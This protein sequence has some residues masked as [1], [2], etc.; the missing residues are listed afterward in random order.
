MRRKLIL[1]AS[2]S[3]AAALIAATLFIGLFTN[4]VYV[5]TPSMY[6]TIPPGALVFIQ[7]RPH[8][9]VGDVIEFHG[10]GLVFMHRITEID[11]NGDI[12]TKGDNPENA[13]D[14]F[15]TPITD[16]DVIGKA[17]YSV[18]WVGFPELILHHPGYGLS[19]L[20]AEL[21]LRGRLIVLAV[22]AA[23]F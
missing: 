20:R 7:K 18:K 21:G 8:Y 23:V 11:A 12:I 1:L 5:T 16:A 17:L 15:E 10:N 3:V 13:P 19:W 14:A 22:C 4:H 9:H 6:P 2:G